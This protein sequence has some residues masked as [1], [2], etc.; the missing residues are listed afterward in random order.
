MK[1][2]DWC[3]ITISILGWMSVFGGLMSLPSFLASAALARVKVRKQL[4]TRL[5]V[6]IVPQ[7]VV[8]WRL[9]G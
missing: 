6:A 7:L 5:I 9:Y 2:L 1:P 3:L 4:L 8:I